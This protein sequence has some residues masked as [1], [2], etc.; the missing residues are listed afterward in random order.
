MGFILGAGLIATAILWVGIIEGENVHDNWYPGG[1]IM[2]EIT[3]GIITGLL[4]TGLAW[5]MG[6]H[7]PVIEKIRDDLIRL[8][9]FEAMTP[10][11]AL[12][13]GVLAAF[14]EEIFFRGALQ[15]LLG[16]WLTALIFGALHAV[17]MTYFIYTFFAGIGLGLLVNWRGDLWASTAAHFSYDAALF[18]LMM[19]HARQK[20]TII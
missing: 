13:F 3:L 6:N 1:N 8:F 11:H 18:M 4:S 17:S 7:I 19:W 9:N 5:L 2:R 15:P 14:P 16:L 20:N 10:S 12:L